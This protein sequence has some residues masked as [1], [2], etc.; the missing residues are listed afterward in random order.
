[1]APGIVEKI[2]SVTD[3]P[4]KYLV[5]TH[6]HGDHVGGN[7]VFRHF[8][9]IIA[10]DNVRTRM[11]ASPAEILRD[12]PARVEAARKA[13]NEQQ[14]KQLSEQLEAAK[15]V[16]IEE[17]GAPVL[18]FDSE[19]RIHVGDETV[20]VWHTPPAHTDGDAVIY[21]EK[22]NVL[23]MGDDFFNKVIPFIDVAHGGSVKGYLVA[24]DKVIAKVPASVTIIPGHGE[25]TDLAGLKAFRQYVADL[26]D[27]ARK[28]KA[29]AMAKDDF[30][31]QVDLPAYKGYSGYADRFKANAASAWDEAP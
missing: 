13:G 24:L 22:A 4:I 21:F 28:A 5:N 16:K 3:K 8:A 10:H 1:M 30:L 31:K 12:F 6:H 15:S 2:K 7:E 29:A 11:L 26:L 9:V 20:Q 19:V 14:A 27:A 17:I 18:T 25:V 23:H